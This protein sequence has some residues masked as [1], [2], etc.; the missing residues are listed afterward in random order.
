MVTFELRVENGKGLADK[1]WR[2]TA[3][4]QKHL[5]YLA[6]GKSFR[7]YEEKAWKQITLVRCLTT[8]GISTVLSTTSS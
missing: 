8:E 4:N 1:W 7:F 5:F 3:Q 2:L 6:E